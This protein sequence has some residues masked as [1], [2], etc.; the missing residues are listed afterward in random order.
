[1]DLQAATSP[2]DAIFLEKPFVPEKL[3]GCIAK[4]LAQ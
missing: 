4:S 1:M 3:I 2:V